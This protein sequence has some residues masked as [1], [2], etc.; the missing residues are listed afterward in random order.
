MTNYQPE[1]TEHFEIGVD[2]EAYTSLEDLVDKCAYYLSHET[3]RKQ[4]AIN[5]YQKVKKYHTYQNRIT[6][7]LRIITS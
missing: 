6:E 5:G 4:I 7:M 3:E 2:L 1:L